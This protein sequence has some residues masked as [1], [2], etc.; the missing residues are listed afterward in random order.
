LLRERCISAEFVK[1]PTIAVY[2]IVD[3][4]LSGSIFRPVRVPRGESGCD[5]AA[6]EDPVPFGR[7]LTG[8][9][10]ATALNECASYALQGVEGRLV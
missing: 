8:P 5:G 4:G 10:V 9:D 2:S 3:R 1:F 6:G 7:N